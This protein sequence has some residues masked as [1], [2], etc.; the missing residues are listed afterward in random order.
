MDVVRASEG[1]REV[2]TLSDEGPQGIFE[3]QVESRGLADSEDRTDGKSCATE[4]ENVS[5][6]PNSSVSV[7]KVDGLSNEGIVGSQARMQ[8]SEDSEAIAGDEI[9]VTPDCLDPSISVEKVED[10]ASN[11]GIVGSQARMQVSEDSEA[12][13][14]DGID[15]TPDCLD[16]SVTVEKVEGLSKEGLVCIKAKMQVSEDSEAVTGDGIDIT[17]DC[18][19]VPETV[20]IVGDSSLCSSAVGSEHVDN[21]SEAN[22]DT[23]E[24]EAEVDTK[25]SEAGVCNQ[26]N[27]VVQEKAS[28]CMEHEKNLDDNT[29]AKLDSKESEAGDC[30]QENQ[31]KAVKDIEKSTPVA[32][33]ESNEI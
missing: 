24:S 28:E 23:K 16:P 25:E 11:E 3:T 30:N 14:G 5:E 1:E 19:A 27:Q 20:S 10:G 32:A 7:E 31:E 12:I 17:P 21:L 2:E 22:I 18:L 13:A 33:E 6:V 15:V 26:E 4:M 29:L 9:D 8:V